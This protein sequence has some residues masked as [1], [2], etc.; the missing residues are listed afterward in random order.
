M[1]KFLIDIL[2]YFIFLPLS[3]SDILVDSFGFFPTIYRLDF[4]SGV[5]SLIGIL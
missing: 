5:M 3:F 1:N 2:D 4:S